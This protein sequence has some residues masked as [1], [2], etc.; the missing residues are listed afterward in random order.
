MI[1]IQHRKHEDPEFDRLRRFTYR[2][3][4]FVALHAGPAGGEMVTRPVR[5]QGNSLEVN[6]RTS[7]QG[8][9]RIE[10]Q[11]AAGQAIEG[12]QLENC[13]AIR[14]DSISHTVKWTGE[15]NLGNLAG[16]P[17]R[18]RFALQDADVF[19]FRFAP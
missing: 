19:S 14:G 1:R 8:T 10:L 7:G 5:F 13:P 16:A 3:D 9:L 18:L 17:V 11:D 15:T 4:G 2:V 6:F 12:F